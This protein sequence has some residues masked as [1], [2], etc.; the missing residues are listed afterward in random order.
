MS[1]HGWPAARRGAEVDLD[2]PEKRSHPASAGIKAV[3]QLALRQGSG[4]APAFPAVGP[5]SDYYSASLLLL[6]KLAFAERYTR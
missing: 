2:W 6:A 1:T 4:Q 3:V 5:D